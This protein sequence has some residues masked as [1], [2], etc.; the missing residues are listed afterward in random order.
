MIALKKS[1]GEV[2]STERVSFFIAKGK[3]FSCNQED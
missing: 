2:F 1:I 3:G